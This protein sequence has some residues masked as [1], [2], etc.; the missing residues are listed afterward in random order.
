[1][2]V[3]LEQQELHLSHSLKAYQ[4]IVTLIQ[5]AHQDSIRLDKF[6]R[7]LFAEVMKLGHA[8]L[9]DFI[10]AAGDGDVG[11]QID[12][13]GQV[14]RRS[15]EKQKRPYRSI[16]GELTIER[17][18][19]CR[20]KKSKALAKP[21]DQKLGL[22]ADEVS[23][24]LEDW[25]GELSVDLPFAPVADWLE[26]SLG[27]QVPASMAHR[28]VDKLGSYVEEFNEQRES[29]PLKD[30]QD[31]LVALA[32]GK[33]VPVRTSFDQRALEELGIKPS[34]RLKKQKD[35]PTSKHRHVLGDQKSQRATAGAFYSIAPHPRT[36]KDVLDG[37]SRD[38]SVKNK[39]LWAEMNLLGEE[40]VSRG[41]ERVFESLAAERA[42]R[43]PEGKKTLV[44]LMDGDRHL[45]SLQRKYL[46]D[47][48]E[49]LD[50]FH[51]MERLWLA[52]HCFHAEASLEAEEWVQRHLAML[53]ENKV[54][55]V[56]GLLQR[57]INKERLS[58]TK[59][60]NLTT[61]HQ[62]FSINRQRMQYGTYLA[63]GYPIG[64]GVIE[65]ACKH[66]IGDRMCGTGM[67]WEF[68]GAQRMLDLRVTKL[69]NEWKEFIEY[70][71]RAEQ[72]QLYQ[73]AV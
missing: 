1:M 61:V 27:I 30:E 57:E 20:R 52:A 58:S 69:N 19:Y 55:S 38:A 8:G 47:A 15:E 23:Y 7:Q 24:V 26:S 53:L 62:Y 72:Q 71:I 40:E 11:E 73:T 43:D 12:I 10:E 35:Y 56:R 50:I 28:R 29:V 45:R 59:L 16:F 54:D 42:E 68:E 22:P 17:Y 31:I 66:V 46:P 67:R 64:S 44:C 70:R 14:V 33:G 63:A 5:E 36:V 13:E 39:R 6:E 34:Q 32:D 65:G 60:K 21:L 37:K 2:S 4:R 18:V 48:V 9:Q 25:M 51:V 49:I 41:A 3:K